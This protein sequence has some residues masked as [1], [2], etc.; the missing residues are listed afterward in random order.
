[1]VPLL[2]IAILVAMPGLRL[3]ALQSIATHQTLVA[4]RELSRIAH[5]VDRRRKPVGAMAMRHFTQRPQRVLQ[6]FAQA[7][8]AL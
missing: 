7:L 5:I 1:M 4:I 3:L 2:H 8:E 6:P